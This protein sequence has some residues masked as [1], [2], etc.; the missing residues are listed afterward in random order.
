MKLKSQCVLNVCS[1]LGTWL[2]LKRLALPHFAYMET[3]AQSNLP[4]PK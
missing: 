1:V 3:E 4:K 2:H